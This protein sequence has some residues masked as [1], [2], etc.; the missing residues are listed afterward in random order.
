[1]R[2]DGP[3]GLRVDLA[4]QECSRVIAMHYMHYYLTL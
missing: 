1:M 3:G 4:Y 2:H